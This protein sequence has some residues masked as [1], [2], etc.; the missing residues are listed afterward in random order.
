MET[1]LESILQKSSIK[2]MFLVYC[3]KCPSRKAVHNGVKKSGKRFA[4]DEEV[5][6]K[7]RKWLRQQS[8][9]LYAAGFDELLKRWDKLVGDI[10]RN[11]CFFPGSNITCFSFISICDPFI[12]S[13]IIPVFQP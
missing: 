6:R 5:E 8:K 3:G 9:Y 4:D 12:D 7:A 11:K 1:V 2:E 10:S 13:R